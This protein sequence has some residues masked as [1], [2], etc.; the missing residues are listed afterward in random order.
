MRVISIIDAIE[1]TEQNKRKG[2]KNIQEAADIEMADL[3]GGDSSK[4]QSIIDKVVAHTLKG[5]DKVTQKVSTLTFRD[6]L[7]F[8]YGEASSS[9]GVYCKLTSS[10]EAEQEEDVLFLEK[11][12]GSYGETVYSATHGRQESQSHQWG[13]TSQ[14]VQEGAR[15]RQG[16]GQEKVLQLTGYRQ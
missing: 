7:A 5:K 11:S 6:V 15:Q 13:K 14:V 9:Q 16:Q 4:I 3:A 2:K 1:F 12:E 10:S 8:S